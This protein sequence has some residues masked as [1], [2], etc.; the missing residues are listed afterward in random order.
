MARSGRSESGRV[1][2]LLSEVGAGVRENGALTSEALAALYKRTIL[3]FSE[4]LSPEALGHF[5]L[6]DRD[7]SRT[8]S[9]TGEY[10]LEGARDSL[11]RVLAVLALIDPQLGYT[12]GLSF[13]VGS[14]LLHVPETDAFIL[15]CRLLYGKH[16]QLRGLYLNGLPDV[17][18]TSAVLGALIPHTCPA[19][20]AHLQGIG[21]DMPTFCAMC[22]EFYFCL[23]SM[24][25]P[26]PQW[27]EVV[28]AFFADG[29]PALFATVLALLDGLEP[30]MRGGDTMRTLLC[31]KAYANA[32]V[33]SAFPAL[34]WASEKE[35]A[36]ATP[37]SPAPV[38]QST[39]RL[40]ALSSL[41]HGWASAAASWVDTATPPPGSWASADGA[42]RVPEMFPPTTLGE[43]AAAP[44]SAQVK[45]VVEALRTGAAVA[46]AE[47]RRAGAPPPLTPGW[48][49]VPSLVGA[50]SGAP[51]CPTEPAPEPVLC[52][53]P[54]AD[55]SERIRR[56][57]LH[58]ALSPRSLRK[59]TLDARKSLGIPQ[60]DLL[61]P[62]FIPAGFVG[63]PG[64]AG[65]QGQRRVSGSSAGRPSA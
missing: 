29:W 57:R 7:V 31:L 1:W 47:V 32:Q 6:I 15:L 38:Q 17:A 27:L 52:I 65:A 62:A 19:L 5:D 25:L 40:E 51:D 61:L 34:E 24:V 60:A 35:P 58:T 28:T 48:D 18:V 16:Y 8:F 4:G 44:L 42:A 23:F 12:Q 13:V 36:A 22:F 21:M 43:D 50:G 33:A 54:P 39:A 53:S 45:A 3:G 64:A 9:A 26:Q 37:I 63:G 49:V 14:L 11:R 55:L 56:L 20:A 46:L 41:L 30:H 2:L 59:L 10:A